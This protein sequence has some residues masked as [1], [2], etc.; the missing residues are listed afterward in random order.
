MTLNAL[1]QQSVTVERLI[2][3]AL[4]GFLFTLPISSTAKSVFLILAAVLILASPNYRQAV[5]AICAETWCQVGF[6]LLLFIIVACFWSEAPISN[7]LNVIEKYSKLLYLPILVAGFR[8]EK[9]RYWAIHAFLIAM[10]ITSLF[11][12][13]KFTGLLKYNGDDAGQVFRNHIMTGYM[14][15]FGVLLCA[16]LGYQ[17][18][19]WQR[20]AYIVVALLFTFQIFFVNTGRT[21]FILYPILLGIFIPLTLPKK[22]A[23]I[24]LAIGMVAL[25]GFYKLSPVMKLTVHESRQQIHQYRQ[26]EKDTPIGFR[27]QFHHYAN[28]LFNRHLIR[29]LGTAGFAYTFGK[30][31]PIPNWGKKLDEPHSQY[32]FFAAELGLVGCIL[33]FMFLGSLALRALKLPTL[34]VVALGI[35][36]TFIITSY[37]DSMLYYSGTGYFFIVFMAIALGEFNVEKS[38]T[39]V[40]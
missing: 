6:L 7:K 22:S 10:V 14:I 19:G 9:V 26:A 34:R 29:G 11:S 16:W 4:I 18:T 25:L 3:W 30:E 32:W 28:E 36:V 12:I 17:T 21:G 27:F 8:D 1:N 13:M 5:W 39:P 15:D 38:S 20:A 24:L 35:L 33:Y 40:N 37:S 2:P 31:Q 23:C